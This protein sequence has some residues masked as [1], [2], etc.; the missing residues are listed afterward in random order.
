MLNLRWDR[1]GYTTIT[2]LL[3]VLAGMQA[4]YFALCALTV[5]FVQ[6]HMMFRAMEITRRMAMLLDRATDLIKEIME[7]MT[8]GDTED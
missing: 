7:G 6:M 1:I 5:L 3:M 2:V 4:N 8:D